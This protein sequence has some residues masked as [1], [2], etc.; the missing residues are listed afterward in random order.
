[1]LTLSLDLTTG[2]YDANQPTHAPTKT[3]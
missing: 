3:L 2:G 1:V